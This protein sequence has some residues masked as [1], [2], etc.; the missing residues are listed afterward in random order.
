M[1]LENLYKKDTTE[2]VQIIEWF[3]NF[4]DYVGNNDSN[5]YNDACD[6]ADQLEK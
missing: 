4:V 3:N 1:D 6:Y 5:M 2:L